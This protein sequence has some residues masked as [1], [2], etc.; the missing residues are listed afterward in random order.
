MPKPKESPS[1]P[2]RASIGLRL[3]AARETAGL[4]QVQLAARLGIAQHNVSL[5]ECG[6]RMPRVDFVWKW[7]QACEREVGALVG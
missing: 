1:A 7:A 5:Y 3:R 6:N 4:T 2:T